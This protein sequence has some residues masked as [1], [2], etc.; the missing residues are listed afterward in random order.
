[1]NS[2]L[3]KVIRLNR[4]NELLDEFKS[5]KHKGES[6]EDFIEVSGCIEDNEGKIFDWELCKET[7]LK[8]VKDEN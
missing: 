2:E 5:F 4:L 3:I 7:D 6:F 8:E 1:M